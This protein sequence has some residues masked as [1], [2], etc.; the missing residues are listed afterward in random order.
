MKGLSKVT[1][2]IVSPHL[3]THDLV[4]KIKQEIQDEDESAKIKYHLVERM[5]DQETQ[6]FS[7]DLPVKPGDQVI[8]L[9]AAPMMEFFSICIHLQRRLESSIT[10]L[11]TTETETRQ[12]PFVLR[13]MKGGRE[14][15]V[16][17]YDTPSGGCSGNCG[18]CSGH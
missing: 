18:S 17:D 7:W 5:T 13:K 1:H 15:G 4:K 16:L 11:R 8:L 14:E 10:I 2:H 12:I 6:D 9:S 3:E